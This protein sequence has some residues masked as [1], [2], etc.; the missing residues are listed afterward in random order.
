M[1]KRLLLFSIT[2]LLFTQR[3]VAQ[4]IMDLAGQWE[5]QLDTTNELIV[6]NPSRCVVSG[7]INLPSSLAESSYGF[8]TEGSDFGIL[9]PEYKYVGKAWYKREIIIPVLPSGWF[10]L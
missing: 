10:T 1:D 9:T 4:N 8:K 5:V 2:L 6:N 7:S 3:I